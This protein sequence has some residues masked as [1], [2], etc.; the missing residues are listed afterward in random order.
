M[1][2]M[3]TIVTS[4][5]VTGGKM[6]QPTKVGET[7]ARERARRG[8]SARELARQASIHH[9]HVTKLESGA[10]QYP[11]ADIA[12]RLARVFDMTTDEL[13]GSG[14]GG[15]AIGSRPTPSPE[16]QFAEAVGWAVLRA[17]RSLPEDARRAALELPAAGKPAAGEGEPTYR[18]SLKEMATKDVL[19]AW[20]KMDEE[21]QEVL[22]AA[23]RELE[24][25]RSKGRP[26]GARERARG[27]EGKP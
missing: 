5:R 8:W 15:I 3:Y 21:G 13:L 11:G 10:I 7:I 4:Q 19:Q 1:P 2:S 22:L 27:S 9:S 6:A 18:P 17:I 16:A 26:D 12:E 25:L 24:E 14:P 23:A 20:L